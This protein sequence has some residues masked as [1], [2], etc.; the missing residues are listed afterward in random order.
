MRLGGEFELFADLPV[1]QG[2]GHVAAQLADAASER[3]GRVSQPRMRVG[4]RGDDDLAH[5]GGF[6]AGPHRGGDQHVAGFAAPRVQRK[7]FV[8]VAALASNEVLV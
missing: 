5:D 4:G 2:R 3:S 8:G 1:E 7:R 6:V